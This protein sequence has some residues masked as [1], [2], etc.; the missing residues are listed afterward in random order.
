MHPRPLTAP[1]DRVLKG[2]RRKVDLRAS[3]TEIVVTPW[4][5]STTFAEIEQNRERR[6]LPGSALCTN[7]L[8][9]ISPERL[10]AAT[11]SG[12]NLA[13][14]ALGGV[15]PIS[16]MTCSVPFG[17]RIEVPRGTGGFPHYLL[18]YRKMRVCG[19]RWAGKQIG[20]LK[21]GYAYG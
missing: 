12:T 21:P 4:A 16:R 3:V 7:A 8:P 20:K 18:L 17:M 10:I 14:A 13:G 1:P 6:W 11:L 5:S 15:Q 2:H 9:R 19:C